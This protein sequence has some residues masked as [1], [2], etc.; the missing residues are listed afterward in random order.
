MHERK[1]KVDWKRTAD[2]LHARYR[3]E[4][5]VHIAKR[6]QALT[7]LRRG[8]AIRQVAHIVG[9][10]RMS[11]HKWLTW[12]R[13]GG[14][15]ELTR[16]T[17]G[18]NRIPVRPLLTPDQ[19]AQLIQ[20]AATQGFRTLREAVVW[21]QRELGVALSERQMRRLSHRLRF[22]RKVLRPLAV[23]ADAA[24]QAPWKKGTWRGVE[25]TGGALGAVGSVCGRG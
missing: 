10:S 8:T 16:R 1:L 3:Q 23:G 12:S 18:G 24:L 19:Q 2:E 4:R 15:D 11:I 17:R 20:H 13:T 21:S 5:N 9:V 6:L 14:L 25:G 22:R 7:L